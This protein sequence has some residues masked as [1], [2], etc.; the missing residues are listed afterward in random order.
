MEE[1]NAGY[2]I[3]SGRIG[4]LTL[5][6]PEIYKL[7][8]N[9]SIT[10]L[11][12]YYDFQF[13][14]KYYLDRYN[15]ISM[16]FLGS[17]DTWKMAMKDVTK[18]S[19]YEKTG[20]DPL[21]ADL[22]FKLDSSFYNIGSYYSFDTGLF[23]NTLM[24]YA[25]LTRQYQYFDAGIDAP[26][27]AQDIYV[28][29]RP[30]I[31]GLKDSFSLEW[32]KNSAE[33][34]GALEYTYYK[35]TA[36]GKTLTLK[37]STTNFDLGNPDL[38]DTVEVDMEAKNVMYGGFLDNKF[39]FGGLKFVPGVR[40]D[41]LERSRES[42]VSPRGMMSYKFP[43]ETTISFA[44]GLYKSFFQVNPYF[45][46]QNPE[47]SVY[48]KIL[49]PEKALHNVVGVEQ[50]Y[51]LYT[52]GLEGYYNYFYNIAVGY[53]H[54]DE[55]NGYVEGQNSGK[56]KSLGF[57]VMMRK[58]LR[59]GLNDFFGWISYT[60]NQSRYKSGAVGYVYDKTTGTY[61]SEVFDP[62]AER[63]IRN[64]F[65]RE[66]TLKVVLGNKWE[67][68]TL[69]GRFQLYT[70]FPYTPII[71]NYDPTTLSDGRLRYAPIY[72]NDVNTRH[73]P[74][75]HRLDLRLSYQTNYRWGHI[76]WYIEI[77]NVY[78]L[79][80]TPKDDYHWY[81]NRP[82]D[83]GSNPK[84]QKSDQNIPLLPNFGVEIKF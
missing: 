14:A 81:Y 67:R 74:V 22:K 5:I 24:A 39:T 82:Y 27:W 66:H 68:W 69:S 41:Y 64:N 54:Y 6:I 62:N 32:I 71:G 23:K 50:K 18:K 30:D 31:Y 70:S 76:K 42:I 52:F 55:K 48:G 11:P 1:Q 58:D 12:E 21:F 25:S 7:I 84:V 44:S 40:W 13:K 45:F 26:L 19:D 17:A 65:E 29:S 61:G 33:I 53:S 3:A 28:D 34:R 51:D 83:T 37:S 4:Y 72:S 35:F 47:Y 46:A 36:K 9:D 80:Y 79:A 59:Q 8:K 15:S 56:L 75:D 57:E 43:S 38:F 2:I 60:Y 77:I 73:F 20:Q 49:E 10:Y 78:G 63:W 16:L